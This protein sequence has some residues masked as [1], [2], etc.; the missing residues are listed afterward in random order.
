RQ[1]KVIPLQT[2]VELAPRLGLAEGVVM[3]VHGDAALSDLGLVEQ[4]EIARSSLR[5]VAS[6][7]AH[8]LLSVEVEALRARLRTLVEGR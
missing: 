6:R 2:D 8:T 7:A 4:A 1:V 3:L 5:L